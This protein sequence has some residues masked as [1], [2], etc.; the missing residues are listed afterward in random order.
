RA[1]R[2]VCSCRAAG[3]GVSVADWGRRPID[4]DRL[5]E[6]ME[7]GPLSR[8]RPAFR[9]RLARS[10]AMTY[11]SAML[12]PGSLAPAFSLQDD[13]GNTRSLADFA[14]KTLILW[15]FPKADTPGC[16]IEGNGFR[17]MKSEFDA[18]NA[19]ICGVSFDTV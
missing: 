18:K 8:T 7:R 10:A 5:A 3:Q 13:E 16:T 14:G 2:M 9:R 4:D 19:V 17:A 12:Q 1:P 6:R 11:R 15:F